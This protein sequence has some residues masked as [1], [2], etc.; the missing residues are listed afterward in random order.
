M[1]EKADSYYIKQVLGGNREA[2]EPLVQRYEKMV[3]SV[4]AKIAK[5]DDEAREIAQSVFIKAYQAL[6]R[7]K[8]K[9]KFSSWLY[10]IA[11]NTA[12]THVRK[13]AMH[14]TVDENTM[15]EMAPPAFHEAEQAEQIKFL[16]EAIK[17]LKPEDSLLV[18]LYHLQ[19]N[20]LDEVSKQTGLKAG[21]VKVRLHRVRKI[22]YGNLQKL[23]KEEPQSLL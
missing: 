14:E 2:F 13:S 15:K 22:L 1:P 17:M 5:S 12:I 19:E 6:P 8:G 11:Y 23:L 7:F 9:A 4:A 3:F 20:S 10:R 16:R 21:N 18:T